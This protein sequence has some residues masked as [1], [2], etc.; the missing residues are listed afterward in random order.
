MANGPGSPGVFGPPLRVHFFTQ[1]SHEQGT[2]FRFHNLAVG[3]TRIGHRVTVFSGDLDFRARERAEERD[4][5]QYHIVPDYKTSHYFCAASDPFVALRRLVRPYP[6]CDVA[7]LFQPF[8]SAAGGW[9]RS[10]C[11]LRFYDWDD[12][13]TGGLFPDRIPGWRNQWGVRVG[14]LLEAR[15][16]RC[17]THV[18]TVSTFLARR[19]RELADRPVS[20]IH[21][22]FWP[23]AYPDR[24]A[25]RARLGLR[26]DALYAGFMGRTTAELP[27]CFD[28]LAENMDRL[29]ALRMAL[30]GPPETSLSTLPARVRD[31]VDYLGHLTPAETRTFAA[32]LDVG[33]L[34]LEDNRFNQSRFPIK[35]SEHL[36]AGVPLLCS[37]V[38]ECGRLSERFPWA[39]PAG[40]T[41]AEWLRAFRTAVN[42]LASGDVPRYAPAV[43]EDLMSWGT[44]SRRLA[45]VYQAALADRVGR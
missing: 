8:P 41:R 40:T 5:V 4:G 21:N 24:A 19:A 31:R 43:F 29:P 35:F 10:R 39:I 32:A 25:A 12:L 27:W 42:R 2:Y 11:R 37:T 6:P 15:L 23:G 13:W 36:A 38:G 26:P 45:E 18:T 3:L 17:A 22:G 7:H 34:P 30:C 9:L 14:R 1:Y 44:L 16:P 20:V 33:L 28:A